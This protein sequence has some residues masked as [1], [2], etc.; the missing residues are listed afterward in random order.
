ML[1]SSLETDWPHG[2]H[3]FCKMGQRV[4]GYFKWLLLWKDLVFHTSGIKRLLCASPHRSTSYKHKKCKRL[5]WSSHLF[6][7]R[8]LWATLPFFTGFQVMVKSNSSIPAWSNDFYF[9]QK[10]CPIL[11]ILLSFASSASAK[12]ELQT[13]QGRNPST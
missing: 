8:H 4:W 10:D 2:W 12:E 6:H 5:L 11:L 3:W 1:W 13:G 9:R 7:S